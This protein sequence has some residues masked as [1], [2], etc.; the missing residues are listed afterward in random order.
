MKLLIKMTEGT[1]L[2]LRCLKLRVR[3]LHKMGLS[4][5]RLVGIHTHRG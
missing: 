3:E 1:V 2:G 5:T 4:L